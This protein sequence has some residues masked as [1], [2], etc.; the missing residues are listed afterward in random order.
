MKK[1]TDNII[2]VFLMLFVIVFFY[3]KSTIPTKCGYITDYD[4]KGDAYVVTLKVDNELLYNVPATKLDIDTR[5]YQMCTTTGH[6]IYT[7]SFFCWS[8]LFV[9]FVFCLIFNSNQNKK[10]QEMR[11]IINIFALCTTVISIILS[12]SIRVEEI[13]K[14]G[15]VL[16]TEYLNVSKLHNTRVL[17]PNSEIE[18]T[19][20][21]TQYTVNQKICYYS[22]E[23]NMNSFLLGFLQI[24]FIASLVFNLILYVFCIAMYFD[25]DVKD[26]DKN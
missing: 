16:A 7:I 4:I 18:T 17:L 25:T 13:K 2:S 20:F 10:I 1:I 22:K 3:N 21:K 19:K 12:E 6:K 26:D 5:Q 15:T 11:L 8:I 9:F 23:T 14:C 24:L